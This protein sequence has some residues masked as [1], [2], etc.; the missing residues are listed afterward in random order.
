MRDL[1]EIK[2]VPASPDNAK[3]PRGRL[4]LGVKVLCYPHSS[5]SGAKGT[6]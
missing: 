1:T 5:G 2:E 3:G 4:R 6:S